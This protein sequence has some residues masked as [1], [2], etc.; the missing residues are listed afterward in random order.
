MAKIKY[1]DMGTVH[2]ISLKKSI[3]TLDTFIRNII[4]HILDYRDG[5]I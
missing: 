3:K 5:N 4:Q 1:L 2:I